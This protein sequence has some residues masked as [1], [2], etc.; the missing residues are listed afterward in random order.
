MEQLAV[1]LVFAVGIAAFL[2]AHRCAVCLYCLLAITG[3]LSTLAAYVL[4]FAPRDYMVRFP[5]TATILHPWLAAL[6]GGVA[7]VVFCGLA[8]GLLARFVYSSFHPR[9]GFPDNRDA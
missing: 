7:F 2:V 3:I 1:L 5:W 6:Y 8:L 4:F 9:H